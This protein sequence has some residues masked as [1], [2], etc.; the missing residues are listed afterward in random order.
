MLIVP[1]RVSSSGR[2]PGTSTTPGNTSSLILRIRPTEPRFL[3]VQDAMRLALAPPQKIDPGIGGVSLEIARRGQ[4]A[5]WPARRVA[6][7]LQIGLPVRH[8]RE[9]RRRQLLRIKFEPAR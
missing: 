1:A 4:Q 7:F 3:R 6:L 5:Q 2:C 9:P 8:R